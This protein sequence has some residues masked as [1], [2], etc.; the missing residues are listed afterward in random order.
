MNLFHLKN[1]RAVTLKF[2][3]VNKEKGVFWGL[4]VILIMQ[5]KNYLSAYPVT[6]AL[7]MAYRHQYV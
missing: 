2:G 3:A 6:P 7:N 1:F 4:V 5:K